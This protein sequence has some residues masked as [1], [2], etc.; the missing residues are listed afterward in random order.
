[1]RHLKK[2][3]L[4]AF[5]FLITS[6]DDGDFQSLDFQFTDT[7][8]SCGSYLLYR[9]NSSNTEVL[10]I[11]LTD[12]E[13]GTTEGEKTYSVEGNISVIYRLFNEAIGSTYFCGDIPPATPTIIKSLSASSETSISIT[14]T[15][16][17]DS[18]K[19]QYSIVLSNL[20]FEDDNRFYFDT[21]S[22]GTFEK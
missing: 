4:F 7:I 19:Y 15:K 1:M 3:I 2:F 5:M 13:L 11:T 14:T 10:V 16:S 20:L 8:N 9:A 12:S 21:F 6:C 22:F 17:E 18:D